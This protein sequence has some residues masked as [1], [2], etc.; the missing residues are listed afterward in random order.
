MGTTDATLGRDGRNTIFWDTSGQFVDRD[1]FARTA[2]EPQYADINPSNG[3]ISEMDIGFN[4]TGTGCCLA[5]G[6][7]CNQIGFNPLGIPIDWNIG[8]QGL[9]T[10]IPGFSSFAAD[11]QATATHEIGHFL[12]LYHSDIPGATMATV[13]NTPAFYCTTDQVSLESDDVAGIHFLYPPSGTSVPAEY[14]GVWRGMGQH[15][16][17]G[18]EWPVSMCIPGGA[19][20]T[21]VGTFAYPT[22]Y[23]GGELVLLESSQCVVELR[24]KLVYGGCANGGKVVLSNP[25]NGKMTYEWYY[26]HGALGATGSLQRVSVPEAGIP[27]EFLG[28]WSGEG[29]Q[30]SNGGHWS[31][32][33]SVSGGTVGSTVG[34]FAYPSLQCG[35]ELVLTAVN[36]NPSSISVTEHYLFNPGSCI[37]DGTDVLTLTSGSSL[38]YQW[39][40]PDGTYDGIGALNRITLG[41][42]GVMATASP[43]TPGAR[44][45]GFSFP[46][47]PGVRYLV[48]S[49]DTVTASVWTPLQTFNGDGSLASFVEDIN[50]SARR[51]Y[52]V[53]RLEISFLSFPLAKSLDVSAYT[54]SMSA[55]LDHSMSAAGNDSNGVVVAYTGEVGRA[56]FGQSIWH[57]ENQYG[58]R[59][60]ENGTL[61]SICGQYSGDPTEGRAFLFYDGHTGYDYPTVDGTA[62]Y[63][64]A[65][66]MAEQ[67]NFGGGA[68]DVKITHGNGYSTFYLHLESNEI[69]PTA[70]KVCRDELIG[71]VGSGHLHFTVKK[72]RQRVD[73]YGWSGVAGDD[74]L[75]VDGQ[76]NVCL[77]LECQNCP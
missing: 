12:G 58:F 74:P 13:S 25:A 24:E 14:A 57:K 60:D 45:L 76:D 51:F 32:L 36:S 75:R 68:H 67:D 30:F 43:T 38:G 16:G 37:E 71:R 47:I 8:E 29:D 39:Y 41:I 49:A 1:S 46:T 34:T 42:A 55:V 19:R 62:V 77:W 23:C 17:G 44:A 69:G 63:A 2:Y 22:Y 6:A 40:Q 73:P 53:Q 33:M 27:S 10:L 4:A 59:Q 64:A 50:P 61:F 35:G 11:V 31:I 28:A 9:R 65:D 52:R 21:T 20:G 5:T 70:R 66:G 7:P 56:A 15:I 48:E 18:S 26:S 72:G 54:A 3:E